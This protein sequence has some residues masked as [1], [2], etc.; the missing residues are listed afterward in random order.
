M[1]GKAQAVWEQ[2]KALAPEEQ[3]AV[4]RELGR[5][6]GQMAPPPPGGTVRRTA[7]R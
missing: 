2:I 6:L 4:W 7:D 3:Q 5:R 1:S